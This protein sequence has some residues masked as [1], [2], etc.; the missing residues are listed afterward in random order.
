MEVASHIQESRLA[1]GETMEEYGESFGRR[2]RDDPCL[3]HSGLALAIDIGN[4]ND[5]HPQNKQEVGRR[6][7]LIALA[8]DYGKETEYSGP[9][10]KRMKVDGGKVR[11]TFTHIAG[12][13]VAKGDKLTGFAIAGADRKFEWADAV[14][15]GDTV[16]VSSPQVPS[17]VAVRYAWA[18]NPVCSLYNKSGLP[19][20]PFRTD[21][22]PVKSGEGAKR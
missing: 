10:F 8:K 3:K 9:E 1:E 21:D 19:A 5:I 13:L 22:W 20:S 15:D 6:L 4:P 18:S 16:V 11:L 2:H 12:G 17:P 14:I 7:A